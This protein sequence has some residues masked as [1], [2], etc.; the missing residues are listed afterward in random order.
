M[1][2]CT[3]VNLYRF[4]VLCVVAA[5]I[6]TCVHVAADVYSRHIY[7]HSLSAYM[8]PEVILKQDMGRPMDV[9]SIGCVVVE[10]ATGKVTLRVYHG[11]GGEGGNCAF[12]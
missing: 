10:M 7:F 9:W 1:F 6:C 2:A 3:Y 5:T 12:F 4:R 11:G 8:S